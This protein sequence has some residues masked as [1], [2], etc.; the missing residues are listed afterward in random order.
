MPPTPD[1][2]QIILAVNLTKTYELG[3]QQVRALKEVSLTIMKMSSWQLWGHL[4]QA[5]QL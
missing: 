2:H 5:S 3:Y 4:V 1:D